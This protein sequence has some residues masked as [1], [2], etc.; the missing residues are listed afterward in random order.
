MYTKV[1][2]V[3]VP[4]LAVAAIGLG[5]WGYQEN[6]EKN[7]VLI[8]AENQYQRA[9]HDLT[10]HMD[11]LQDELGKTL[12]VNSRRQI[13]GTLSNVWR[14][15]AEARNEV[16]QLPLAMLPFSKTEEFLANIGKFSYNAAIRDLDKDPL[17]EKEYKQLKGYHKQAQEIQ[18]ELRRVQDQVLE[19]QLRWMDVETSLAKE[20]KNL[21]NTIADGFRTIDKTVD[22][23]SDIEVGPG[24][25]SLENQKRFKSENLKGK[26]ITQEEAKQIAMEFVGLKENEAEIKVRKTGK[27]LEYQAFSVAISKPDQDDGINLDVTTKGGH[28]IWLLDNTQVQDAKLD[29]NQAKQKADEF[30][31]KHGYESMEAFV[32][33]EYNNVATLNYVYKQENVRIYPDLVTVQV[34]LDTGN[35]IGF[36]SEHYT[37]SHKDRTLPTPKLTEAQARKEVNPNL[38]IQEARLA[39][40]LDDKNQETLCYEFMGNLG[41]ESYRVFINA[42]NGEEETI[43]KL[44]GP[45]R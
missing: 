39:V 30:L 29:L 25:N 40:I 10:F 42:D 24:I 18:G 23:Y 20:E 22:E 41:Q 2:G 33:D 31:Q 36:Q 16:G 15:T 14:I 7:R 28:V 11:Q 19:R 12:A 8:K 1:A 13:D 38:K 34:A 45:E 4:V 21:D 3:M 6:Q 5:M 35:V 9:F 32:I 17:S 44:D 43:E 37:F 27:G 26:P